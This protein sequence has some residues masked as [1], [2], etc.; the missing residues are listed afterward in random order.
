MHSIQAGRVR[1]CTLLLAVMATLWTGATSAQQNVAFQ[2]NIPVAPTGLAGQALGA[3]PWTYPTAENMDIR[4]EVVQRG[5]EYPMALT[6]LPD[7]GGMLVV[8][9]P[10]KLHL[11]KN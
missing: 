7:D 8:S 2:G 11:L 1:L 3:G 9:R 6:F 10:G 4:V 5:I